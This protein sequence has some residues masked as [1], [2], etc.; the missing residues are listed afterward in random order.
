MLQDMCVDTTASGSAW[1]C[2][3][4]TVIPFDMLPEWNNSV[5]ADQAMVPSTAVY[6]FL[7]AWTKT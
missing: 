5:T 1:L 7:I 6:L 4:N 2:K 3:G